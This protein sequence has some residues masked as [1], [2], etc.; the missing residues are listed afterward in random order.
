MDIGWAVKT[1]KD[2]GKVRRAHWVSL[3]GP[4]ETI[5]LA[6]WVHLYYEHRDGHMPAVMALRSDGKASHFP[7]TELH[8]MADDWELEV[9]P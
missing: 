6:S 7:M 9:K 5:S 1:M 8:L 4:C 2:G 3:A